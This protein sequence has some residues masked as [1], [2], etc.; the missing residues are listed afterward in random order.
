[1]TNR[2]LRTF[3]LS[4]VSAA[5]AIGSLGAAAASADR[6]HPEDGPHHQGKHHHCKG[7]TGKKRSNCE[8]HHHHGG[9]N[10]DGPNHT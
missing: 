7:L 3:A 9:G 2:I 1:M 4:G 6:D 8:A 5:L 10:D